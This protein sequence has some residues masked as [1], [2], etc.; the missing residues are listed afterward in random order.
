MTRKLTPDDAASVA[1]LC[2][3][4]QEG[5]IGPNSVLPNLGAGLG[6]LIE[7]I[8]R[9]L[10]SGRRA[11]ARVVHATYDGPLGGKQVSRARLWKTLEK[12]TSHW[13]P[14]DPETRP[15][16]E[17]F[18]NTDIVIPRHHGLFPT[19]DSELLTVLGNLGVRTV[20]LSG[21]SLNVSLPVTA[22]H[23]T[24]AGFDLIVPRETAV[25][26]PA[27]YG[28]QVLVNTIAM[29]GRVISLEDLL[30]EWAVAG[31]AKSS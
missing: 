19:I 26:I 1:V 30:S 13:Q 16:P 7:N 22:A 20:I 17:L 9:L 10:N 4:C 21:V 18:A 3:E 2:V 29:L 25:G 27:E 23:L 6:E 11:G 12:A 31:S 14:G 15:L 8:R 5:V 24:Q 28:Q